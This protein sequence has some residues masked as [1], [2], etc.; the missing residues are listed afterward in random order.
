MADPL[1]REERD[2]DIYL[3]GG[4]LAGQDDRAPINLGGRSPYAIIRILPDGQAHAY[5]R[6]P[7]NVVDGRL[8]YRWAGEA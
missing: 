2:V 4:P 6:E 3:I 7:G 5:A 1:T 8:V